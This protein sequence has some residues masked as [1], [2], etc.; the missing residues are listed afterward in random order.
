MKRAYK[1]EIKVNNQQAIKIRK[2]IGTCRY[3]HNMYLAKQ[4]DYYEET[5]KLQ[6]GFDRSKTSNQDTDTWMDS[7][8]RIRLYV[9]QRKREKLYGF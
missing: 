8:E 7:F 4:K 2:T 6:D 1:T 9:P 3:I 5:E